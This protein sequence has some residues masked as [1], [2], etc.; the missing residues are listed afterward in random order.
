MSD[1]L[2]NDVLVFDFDLCMV[3]VQIVLGGVYFNNSSSDLKSFGVQSV[4]V[5]FVA[6][7]RFVTIS[8]DVFSLTDEQKTA[9]FSP[10]LQA[11]TP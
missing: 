9:T 8:T 4:L 5:I 7:A 6:N 3:A 11:L 2:R 10:Q 1:N